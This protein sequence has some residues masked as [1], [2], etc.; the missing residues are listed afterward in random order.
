VAANAFQD[1]WGADPR[2]VV[3]GLNLAEILVALGQREHAVE[4]ARRTLAVLDD[5]G[6]L[7]E[8]VLEAVRF[9]SGYDVFRM[10]W[11][12]AA[13]RNAGNRAAEAAA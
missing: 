4:Q 3:A 13:W 2:H 8:M 12:R 5:L 7:P 6:E 9:P 11:E 10:E 1:A